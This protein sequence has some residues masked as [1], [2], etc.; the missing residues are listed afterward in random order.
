MIN[1]G[2]IGYGYWGPNIVRNFMAN[3]DLNVLKVSDMSLD[4]LEVLKKNHP[5]ISA[6]QDANSILNDP[7]ID[8]VGI[9]TST[10]THFNLAKTALENGK[11]VFVEKPFTATSAEAKELI[12]LADKKNLLIMVDHTFLFTGAVMKMKELTSNGTLGN[13][14][15]YDSVRVNLGLFQY[16]ANVIW[17]LAPHDL[18]IMNYINN[19]VKPISV[20]AVGSD[21]I[22]KG[23]ED[24]AYL[25]VKCENNFIGH[26]HANW[27][28][29]VKV[30]KTLVAG[31][32]KML[33]WDDLEVDEKIKIY[34]KRVEEVQDKSE[35][36]KLQVKYHHGDI[37]VPV[38]E[39][40]EALKLE[41]EH[42]VDC[43]KNKK[44]PI[45][46][47]EEGLEVVKILEASDLSLKNG[48]KEIL[49]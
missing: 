9:I 47:G 34:N 8:L 33:V 30:R 3:P 15:Y 43:I 42:L 22:G 17:D 14:Y 24:V 29:P 28:S 37:L 20:N 2:V 48:G 44:K 13:L 41:T 4:R 27:L 10:S 38:V 49:L 46:G 26:F 6:E 11:H 1:V 40:T 18:S 31:D 32:K 25:T 19:G 23:F 36:Y 16:D 5:E 7:N 12:E 35:F 45:N 39:M 21:H